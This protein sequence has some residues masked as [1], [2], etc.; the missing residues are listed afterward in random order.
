M[1]VLLFLTSFI[2]TERFQHL[3]R[4]QQKK[5]IE[6][7]QQEIINYAKLN[8]EYYKKIIPDKWERLEDI[9]PTTKKM[10]MD[11]FDDILTDKSLTFEQVWE[12][13]KNYP[14]DA[15]INDKYAIVMTSGTTGAPVVLLRDREE[16]IKDSRVTM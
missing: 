15:V 9:P 6:K 7:K 11:N 5:I 14:D 3:C 13:Y 1:N 4:K 2:E 8:S 10:W 12:H 16:F